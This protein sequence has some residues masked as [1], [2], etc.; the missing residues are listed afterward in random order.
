MIGNIVGTSDVD[1]GLGQNLFSW[2][3][4][5][6]PLVTLSTLMIYDDDSLRYR[7]LEGNTLTVTY[8]F[9]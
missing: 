2:V 9:S 3:V 4:G 5:S 6:R 7:I 8:V 1:V